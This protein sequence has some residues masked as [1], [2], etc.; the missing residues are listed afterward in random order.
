MRNRVVFL[1]LGCATR[2]APTQAARSTGVFMPSGTN[3]ASFLLPALLLVLHPQV[4]IWCL[5]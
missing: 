3:T 1:G 5:V 2:E 4:C